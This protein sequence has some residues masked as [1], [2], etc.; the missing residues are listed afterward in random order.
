MAGMTI[1]AGP[2]F[3][4]PVIVNEFNAVSNSRSLRGDSVDVHFGQVNGN[5]GDW[6]ELAVVGTGRGSTVDMRG[7]KIQASRMSQDPFVA[8]DTLELNSNSFWSAVPAGT[9]LTFTESRTAEGGMDTSLNATDMVGSEGWSHSNIWMGDATLITYTDAATNGYDLDPTLGVSG[10]NLNDVDTQ[11][12]ILNSVDVVVFGPVGERVEPTSNEISSEEIFALQQ[13]ASEV[14][15]PTSDYGDS[16]RGGDQWVYSTFGEPNQWSVSGE[17]Y[18]QTFEGFQPG[19]VDPVI[20]SSQRN[21]SI[22]VGGSVSYAIDAFDANGESLSLSMMQGPSFLTL[23]DNGNGSGTLSGVAG[24]GNTGTSVVKIRAL[25]Q[26]GNEHVQAF[27]LNVIPP[28]SPIIVNE[29]NAVSSTQVLSEDWSFDQR[30]GLARGNGDDWIELVVVGNGVSGSSL[31]LRGWRVVVQEDGVPAGTIVFS[32]HAFWQSVQVGTILTFTESNAIKGGWDT[33]IGAE[34]RYATEGWGWSNIYLKDATYLD[35]NAG[36]TGLGIG[37]DD[38][39]IT[40]LDGSQT[41]VAGP[42]GEG[43]FSTR[44]VNNTEVFRLAVDPGVSVTPLNAGFTDGRASTFGH[45]NRLPEEDGSNVGIPAGAASGYQSFTSFATGASSAAP[46]FNN[47]W[48]SPDTNNTLPGQSWT[49]PALSAADPDHASG[50]LS[51]SIESQPGGVSLTDNGDGTASW[52]WTPTA[53]QVG[54]H[55]ITVKVSDPAG[56]FLT[57]TLLVSVMPLSAPVLLNEYN[58][59]SSSRFLNDG[60]LAA[61]LDGGT[62]SDFF[63]GRSQGNGGDWLEFVVV[64]TGAANSTVDLRGWT[65]EISENADPTPETIVLSQDSYWSAVRAGTILTFA[66]RDVIDGGIDSGIHRINRFNDLGFAWTNVAI[67]DSRFV[68]QVAS[69]F[70][71]SIRLTSS[72]TEI[73]LKDSLGNVRNGPVG[74]PRILRNINSGEVFHLEVDPAP[75]VTSS[76]ADSG[77]PNYA[78]NSESSSFGAP[79]QW[80][81]DDGNGGIVS[82]TQ[83]FSGFQSSIDTNSRP[84]FTLLPTDFYGLEGT[85]TTQSISAIDQ[86]GAGGLSFPATGSPSWVTLTDSGNGNGTVSWNPPAGVSGYQTVTIQVSDGQ[87]TVSRSFEIFVHPAS[88]PI[89]VNEYNGVSSSGFLNDGTFVMD[90]EGGMAADGRLGRVEGN[91]G[92]WFELVV[93]GDDSAGTMDLRGWKVEIDED[94]SFSFQANVMLEFS[95]DP[96]WANVAHGTIL[97]F[98]EE[99]TATGGR[100]TVIKGEDRSGTEGWSWSN[101]WVGDTQYLDYTNPEVNGFTVDPGTGAISGFDITSVRTHFVIKNVMDV[102]VYGPAGEGVGLAGGIS[103]ST[104][105]ELVGDPRTDVTPLQVG[106]SVTGTPGASSDNQDSSFG[107]PNQ[108]NDG[109]AEQDFSVFVPEMPYQT[110]ITSLGFTGVDALVSADP[111]GDGLENGL[112]F[113]LGSQADDA[114]SMV[115]QMLAGSPTRELNFLRRSGGTQ[116]DEVY[117]VDGHTLVVEVSSDL[118]SWDSTSVAGTVLEGLPTA[119]AGYEHASFAAPVSY[120]DSEKLFFRVRVNFP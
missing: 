18:R 47:L 66:D 1:L 59:V 72:N 115:F 41:V 95:N 61:D 50:D 4:A 58:A 13:T 44:T 71:S 19:V 55:E 100:D 101:I 11:F 120:A 28:T 53:G 2:C 112:E 79:N 80:D 106:D 75:G 116:V 51:F 16:S 33:M 93:V 89:L 37:G 65:I 70:G 119:P 118:L 85:L 81:E 103:N 45:P 92:D 49:G 42:F 5:G 76:V 6:F 96:Y 78:D 31:D 84:V 87:D 46:Y 97:T 22:L 21:L 39:R 56:A 12:Q 15:S 30:F 27:V 82:M 110:Y 57:R 102:I 111:D 74:E 40:I 94:S 98:T 60:D 29:Y 14:I 7:W 117:S 88:S 52:S 69:G 23:N 73:N 113:A 114:G 25:D 20:R 32:S 48:G 107:Q 8:D 36:T 63:F 90:S 38:T 24:A 68:D 54:E 99:Q 62:A 64:G 9:I 35:V 108:W 67:R 91:G 109:A 3:A 86:D 77:F 43:S 83:D 10:Y 34:N 26:S 17:L 104:I 105:W